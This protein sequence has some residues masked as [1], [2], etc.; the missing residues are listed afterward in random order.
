MKTIING[1]EY[2]FCDLCGEMETGPNLTPGEFCGICAH[3]ETTHPDIFQHLIRV[4]AHSF[5]DG[6]KSTYRR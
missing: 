6:A 3:V 1:V 4:H 5:K 2:K